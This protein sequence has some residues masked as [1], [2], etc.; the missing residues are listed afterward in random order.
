HMPHL[1]IIWGGWLPLMLAALLH[2]WKHSTWWTA[3][4]FGVALLM[5]GL[6]NVHYFLF[7]TLAIAITIFV[8]AFVAP[9]PVPL[10]G[11]TLSPLS[12]GEG[13]LP[14]SSLSPPAGRGQGEG[15]KFW[16]RLAVAGGLAVA[17]MI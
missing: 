14:P 3:A 16:L 10:R 4:G 2:Y 9:H 15:W 17:L 7:G 13:P 8:L 6:S 11:T 12:R 5:N 1:Q